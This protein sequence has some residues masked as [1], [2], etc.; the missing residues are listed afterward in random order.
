MAKAAAR[1]MY[2]RNGKRPED[3]AHAFRLT[4]LREGDDE[5]QRYDD[6]IGTEAHES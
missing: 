3:L 4:A 2:K 6:S 1:E 5:K